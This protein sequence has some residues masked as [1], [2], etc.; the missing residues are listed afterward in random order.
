MSKFASESRFDF[1]NGLDFLPRFQSRRDLL[2]D[3]KMSLPTAVFALK[4]SHCDRDLFG[5]AGP[6]R[7]R[8]VSIPLIQE[9]IQ[10]VTGNMLLPRVEIQLYAQN[11]LKSC[12]ALVFL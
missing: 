8:L 2:I 12:H 5:P 7:R 3:P 6:N 4:Q 10:P 1:N 11:P 9:V